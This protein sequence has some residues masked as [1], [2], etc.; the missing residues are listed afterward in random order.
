MK[1]QTAIEEAHVEL[2]AR[3]KLDETKKWTKR[4][5]ESRLGS[6]VSGTVSVATKAYTHKT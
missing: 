4:V 3:R 2:E 6:V 5:Q 1:L